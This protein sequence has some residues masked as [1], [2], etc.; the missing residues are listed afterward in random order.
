MQV[1]LLTIGDEILIGQII[2]TNSAW[3]SAELNLCGFRVVGKS[4]V[5]DTAAEIEEGVRYGLSQAQVVITTGGLGPT[6][7]DITKKVLA[8]MFQSEMG[9]H[10]ETYDIIATYFERLQR[11]VPPS[12]RDQA[13]LPTKAQILP[14]RVGA[15]PAMVFEQNEKLLI[16]L[17][18]VPFEMEH[19]MK[20]QVIPFLLARFKPDLIVHRTVLTS[21]EG[22]SNIATKIEAIESA[23]P[24]HIKLAY[25]PGLGEVR[26]RLSAYGQGSDGQNLEAEVEAY[27]REMV[28][29]IP[30]IVYGYE[31]EKLPQVIGRIL[32]SKKMRLGLA[33]SCTGGFIA[34]QITSI[35]G[36][37]E[38]YEGSVVSYSNALKNKIL[39]VPNAIFETEGAVSEACVIAMAEGANR[40]LNTDISVSVSGILGP[41]GGTPEKPV[42]TVYI[43]ISDGKR[44]VTHLVRVN[45]DREKNI[46][47]VGVYA[48]TY[49]LRF[50]REDE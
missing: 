11:P 44:T 48:L 30:K 33:E 32:E 42:G 43:G 6:K 5:G 7:D 37:S 47:L 26:L 12:M 3:M 35:P 28:S 39:G 29:L 17:P 10:Q 19:L 36:A 8:E 16:S 40:A 41:G 46:R 25:L 27:T 9:F 45:R 49:L 38:W 20:V 2:D 13:S 4:S 14:N 34:H 22:E 23:L 21:M 18:G 31:D 24:P 1:W 50:L 15:A